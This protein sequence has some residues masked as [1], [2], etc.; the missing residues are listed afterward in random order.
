LLC[1][2]LGDDADLLDCLVAKAA[3]ILCGLT[4]GEGVGPSWRINVGGLNNFALVR[5]DGHQGL[6]P[7]ILQ[8][9]MLFGKGN[10][11][12]LILEVHWGHRVVCMFLMST[13]L[14]VGDETPAQEAHRNL[15]F[16]LRQV[17]DFDSLYKCLIFGAS[18]DYDPVFV[19]GL[20]Y[21]RRR[22]QLQLVLIHER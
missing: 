10:K 21:V 7:V 14:V 22:L 17:I 11:S 1:L 2:F 5:E 3:S 8:L 18:L 13:F 9:P 4:L 19:L 6:H 15:L 12:N 16:R 20:S